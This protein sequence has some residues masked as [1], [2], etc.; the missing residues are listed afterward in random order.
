MQICKNTVGSY[1]CACFNGYMLHEN[2][3]DCKEGTPRKRRDFLNQ[4]HCII[5]SRFNRYTIL[6][7]YNGNMGTLLFRP[8]GPN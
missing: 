8:M 3:H 1:M 7:S 4:T 6:P 2:M 5:D